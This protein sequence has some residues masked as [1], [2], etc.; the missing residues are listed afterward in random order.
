MLKKRLG[1]ERRNDERTA[2]RFEVAQILYHKLNRVDPAV[3]MYEEILST[4]PGEAKAFEELGE[5]L[6]AEKRFE[7]LRDVLIRQ[8]DVGSGSSSALADL[9]ARIGMLTTALEGPSPAA[10]ERFAQALS[11][12]PGHA[13]T[14]GFLEDMLGVEDLQLAIIDLLKGPFEAA[15]R[16]ADLADLNEIELQRRGDTLETVSLLWRLDDLYTWSVPDAAKRFR[17]LS[18][19][20]E[21]TPDDPKCWDALEATAGEVEGWRELSSRYEKAVAAIGI[22]SSRVDLALRLAR[23]AWDRLGNV[24]HARKVFQG[25]LELDDSNNDA[26]EALETIYEEQGDHP[27]L[28]KIYR[29]RFEVSPYVGEKIAYAFK[30]ASELAEHLDDVEGAITAVKHIL[31]LEAESTAAYRQ[32][33][34]LYIQAERWFDLAEVLAERVRLAETDTERTWLRLRLAEVR[35]EKLEDVAGAVE[36]YHTILEAEPTNEDAVKQLERLFK[37]IDVRVAIA[38]ILLPAYEA[39]HDDE[40]LVEVYEVLAEA[41]GDLD[42]RLGHYDTI[43]LILESSIGD[44]A[45]AFAV[46]ARAFRAAPDRQTLVDE[47]LRVGTL[48]NALAEAVDVLCEKAFQIEDP[49]RRKETHRTIARVARDGGLPRDLAKK[50]FAEVLSMDDGDLDALDALIALHRADD[51]IAPLVTLLLR[52]SALLADAD[53]RVALLLQA[54]DLQAHRLDQPEAAVGSYSGVLDLAPGC[55]PAIEALEVL[56]ESAQKW[57]E[58]VEVL[59][60]KAAHAQTDDDRVSALKKKGL[61]QHERL[62]A[63]GEAIETFLEV[64]T[65]VP[66]DVDALR[67]LDRLYAA[68]EDWWNLFGIL[69]KILALVTGDAALT[70]RYRMGRLLERELS[71]PI[72][73]VDTYETLLIEFPEDRDAVDALEGMVRKGEAADEAFRVL[74]PILSERNEWERL[75]VVYEVMTEREEDV[76]HKVTNLL[77]M[78]EIAEHRVGRAITGFECYGKAFTT[79][80]LNHE[81]LDR[82]EAL[83]ATHD[84]WENVPNLLLAGAAAIEG[85]PEA[86][87]LHLRAAFVQRDKVNDKEAAAIT[88]EGV[89]EDFPDNRDALTALDALYGQMEQWKDL[90]RVLRAEIDSTQDATD[91]IA[92]L[93]R[94]AAVCEDRLGKAKDAFEARCEV[95]YLQPAHPGAV[96]ELRQM[97]DAGKMRAEILEVI[98]PIYRETGAWSDLATVYESVLAAV[99]DAGERKA[100][101]LKLGEVELDRLLRHEVALGWLGKALAIEPSDETLLI[102]IEGLAAEASAWAVLLDILMT[103]AIAAEEDERRIYL[104]HKAADVARERLDDKERAEAV[105]RWILDV[106]GSDR[107]AL[108]DLDALY[109]AQARWA[110]LLGVLEREAAA[111]DYDDDKIRFGLRAGALLRDKLNDLDGAVEAFGGILAIDEMHRGAL[112]ALAELHDVRD[113]H[114]ALYKVLG[115]LSD[116][117]PNGKDRAV[118]QRRMARI[119]EQKLSDSDAALALWDEVSRVAEGDTES[120]R[121]LQRLHAAKEDWTAFVDACER[122]IALS[123]DDPLRLTTLLR[124]V[125]K[126][127]EERLADS[128]Q[129]QQAWRRVL[130]VYPDDLPALQSLRRLYRDSGDLEGLSG[131]LQRLADGGRIQGGELKALCEEHARL[132]TDELG[133]NDAAITWWN[134]VLDM[135]SASP[136]ALE[137]LDRLYE[138]TGHLP[139]CVAIVKRRAALATDT[140][141]RAELLIRAAEIEGDRLKDAAAAA[142]TLEEVAGF[143]PSNL[144]VSQRLQALYQRTEEWDRLAEVLLRRDGILTEAEERVANLQELARVYE[145]RKVD[146]E[147]AFIILVKASDVNPGDETTLA[148]LWRLAQT[149]TNWR[150]YVD[151][152]AEVVDRMPDGLR[153][154]HLI[155]NGEVLAGALGQYSE[156]VR[157]YERVIE[158]W[159]EN[160]A[161]LTAMTD[162]YER[163]DRKEDLVRNLEARVELTPD[164]LEKVTLQLKAGRVLTGIDSG[165]ALVAYRKVLEFDDANPEALEALAKL[166]EAN[167]EW[168]DLLGVLGR[169]ASLSP[170]DEVTL[171]V[172]MATVLETSIK[173]ANRAIQAWEDILSL[174]A[175]HSVALDHLQDL[176]GSQENWKGLA[177]V[178][179]RLL[180]QSSSS[181][182]RI[183][184]CN[185]LALLYETALDDKVKALSF[186]QQIL[187]LDPED[188]EA[189]ETCARL[190]TDVEDWNEL[191]NLLEGRIGRENDATRKIALLRRVAEVYEKRIEDLNSAVSVYQRILDLDATDAVAYAELARLFES[192]E[193]W[194]DVVQTILRWKEHVEEAREFAGLMLRAA[195]IVHDR[196]EN[197][198]RALKLLGDVMRMDP[199]SEPAAER[200]RRIYGE[201]EDWEKVAEVWLRQEA[202]AASEDAK[203][204]FRAAAGDVYMNKLK[205]RQRAIQHYERA[206]ELD[207]RL[208]EVALSLAQAYVAAE[209]WEKSE[210]L[211]EMLLRSPDMTQDPARAA[212]I[213]FQMGLCAERLLDFE[214]AFKEYQIAVKTRAEHAP[215]AV[216]LARLYQRKSLW[217]LAKDHFRKGLVLGADLF[218]ESEK[219]AIEFALGEVTLELGE[220]DEAVEHLDMVL[221]LTPNQ[222]RAVDLQV[223]IAERREDWPAVIRYKQAQAAAKADQFERFSVLLECG[224][225]Y[226]EKMGNMYGATAA[227]KEAL[228][229]NPSAKVALLRLFDLYVQTG[230]IEDALYVL[231]RLAQAEDSPEKRAKHYVRMGAIYREKL[232]DDARAIEYLNLALD[233]DPDFLDAFRAIDEILTANR[234]WEAEAENYRR[235]LE[236]LKGRNSPELEY[237]LYAALGEIY[238]S[239]LKRLDYAVSAFSMAAK[240]KPTERRVHEILAQLYEVSGDQMDKAVEEHRAIVATAPLSPEVAPAYKAM[241]RLFLEMKEFDKAFM[242]AS[243]LVALGQADPDEREFFE[244]NLE[245]GLPWFK[246]TIDPLRW[247][248]HLVSKSENTLLGRVLQVLYQGVGSDLG[249]KE[250]KDV[251]LK[252]KDEVDLDLKLL[253]VNVYKGVAKALGPMPHKVYRD[254]SP[255]GLKL[256]FLSPPALIVG[257]DM[258]TGHDEREV[259]FYI[260]RQLS[261]L[262][263]MHFLAT[264]K[265]LT[266]LKIFLAAA[267]K[268][269]KSDTQITTGAD[270]VLQLVRVI[271][272]RMPQQLKNQL[273]KLIDEMA[274]RYPAM[275][276]D[277]MYEEFF[278]GIEATALRSG[279]LV[280]GNVQTVIN[281][282]R[283]EDASFSGM[284]QKDRI[285]EVVRFTLSEDHF[286]LRRA[287]GLAVEAS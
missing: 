253:F 221:M 35:E 269:C 266:E 165:R 230:A 138:D 276:F 142:A 229:I 200:M 137:S 70:V 24:E 154:E 241:R 270:V 155:R 223:A 25:V 168:E 81:A 228:E 149:L 151:S 98:E 146:R 227:Y 225:I 84:M 107:K 67:T 6:L 205:D 167:G 219:S 129:A 189:F 132:L 23:I 19:I 286:I 183:L 51:E 186:W 75:Y 46:R 197:P 278:R 217:Q 213:H 148:D 120:L 238:R 56:F 100:V 10:I 140:A 180:D 143:D 235:M 78:G 97:F 125:A 39:R 115:T 65:L 194:E 133:R 218:D 79:D 101:L 123:K 191:V 147:S 163:L 267:L 251:G 169:L 164:Y 16:W 61:V 50:H 268:F 52:K 60:R 30:V 119:A 124:E 121:E 117:A 111:A 207:P 102:Q 260:G 250:L 246:G 130:D 166:H 86:L 195:S 7:A 113:E 240:I 42:T 206:L 105:C 182:D 92:F 152:I 47:V 181:P 272:R 126:A 64:H 173:D 247:E 144:D 162:L 11:L 179:E 287:L 243:V 224:D 104:W 202:A 204:R 72:K 139:E 258:L 40:K 212:E 190:L 48:R 159:P 94:L 156:S 210:P 88:L 99:E 255:T 33:D 211:L 185:R 62:G 215:T 273:A 108:G 172:R 281:I 4:E 177:A 80:P 31:D 110:D 29:R 93:L 41:A 171:R 214:R 76:A 38:R 282:L 196:L 248:S 58:L 136:A 32:L 77:T 170:A 114:K 175:S 9:H 95:L 271:D 199:G 13:D 45:R 239:R 187:D 259:A 188:D 145:S 118:L 89:I 216:G 256:E 209:H 231:E 201:L 128:F 49:E 135:E 265:N 63:T 261:Y 127:A 18:R 233:A 160:E 242:T 131:V 2:V 1:L 8:V 254:E 109:E 17:T 15:R 263:P 234:D 134:R 74:A 34:S 71:D 59:G 176:Y 3:A 66:Q 153:L 285:D 280:S 57:E 198:E 87:A 103:A 83:A 106:D 232:G 284:A 91:K 69:D 90:V 53:A 28:L 85:R 21:V 249:A 54:G 262:H 5:L 68:S 44:S 244:G 150:D 20:L 245:P 116:I 14:L 257:S 12:E 36:V 112:E 222:A 122:E 226:R 157:C 73:A 264:V 161:A 37:N 279:M 96:A 283:T 203:A 236:R 277:Q 275:D 82:I 43:A 174:E 158:K 208:P 141:P 252:K 26:L 274:T 220:L 192:M 55:Q 22:A 178:Y 184:F 27:E 237:R 193:A